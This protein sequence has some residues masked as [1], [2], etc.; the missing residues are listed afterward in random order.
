MPAVLQI[1]GSAAIHDNYATPTATPYGCVCVCC[2]CVCVC[3][4][5]VALAICGQPLDETALRT[6]DKCISFIKLKVQPRCSCLP[7]C[8]PVA[9]RQHFQRGLP[10]KYILYEAKGARVKKLRQQLEDKNKISVIQKIHHIL[11]CLL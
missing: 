11:S 1:A 7:A 9:V 3:V 6:R 5:L 4:C 2:I 8:L 10:E